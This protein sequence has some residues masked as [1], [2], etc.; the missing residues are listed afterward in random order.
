MHESITIL[1]LLNCIQTTELRW[2]NLGNVN[3]MQAELFKYG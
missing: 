2:K 3:W 1:L